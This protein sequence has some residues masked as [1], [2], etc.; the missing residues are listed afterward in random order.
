MNELPD[1]VIKIIDEYLCRIDSKLPGLVVGLYIY[2]S[3]SLGAYTKGISDIDFLAVTGHTINNYE[4]SILKEIHKE[5]KSKFNETD[6]M[7]S[8]IFSEELELSNNKYTQNCPCFIEGKFIGYQRFD[9]N[10]IDAYQLQKYGITLRGK[11]I[12]DYN[13]HVDWNELLEHMKDNLNTYWLNWM[14]NSSK[15]FSINGLVS[16]ISLKSIEWGVLGVTRQYY[17]FIEKGMTSKV[18]AGEYALMCVP[19]RWHKIL[20]ES[21]R[22]RKGIAKSYYKSVFTRRKDML[23]YMN[24]IIESSNKM[25]G[26]MI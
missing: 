21:M 6:L 23:Q 10:S 17:S 2:G 26:E 19:E 25:L 5:L 12:G 22:S 11:N 13:Y 8:Y 9:H 3:I 1:D 24:F 18:G 15:L 16:S 4:L 20:R 14:T 7:G